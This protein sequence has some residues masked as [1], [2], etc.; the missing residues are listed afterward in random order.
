MTDIRKILKDYKVSE[1]GDLSIKIEP[2]N[3]MFNAGAQEEVTECIS[4]L[5]KRWNLSNTH[6]SYNSA[7]VSLDYPIGGKFLNNVTKNF[8]LE[9]AKD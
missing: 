9:D 5:K 2:T 3:F 6:V 4:K 7:Y 1:N 8:G